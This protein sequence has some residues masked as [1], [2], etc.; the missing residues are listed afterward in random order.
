MST[1][2]TRDV[3]VVAD[4]MAFPENPR[5]RDGRLYFSDHLLA[6]INVVEDGRVA[7]LIEV[8]GQPAGMGW[9]P[10]GEHLVASMNDRRIVRV[11]DGELVEWAQ[12][13]ALAPGPLNDMVVGPGGRAYV[14]SFGSDLMGGEPITPTVLVR[15]DPDG[16][17]VVAAEDLA[18]PNGTAITS[19]G[20]TLVIAETYGLRLT[21]FDIGAGGELSNR[22]IWASFGEP[23]A[24]PAPL[25]EVYAH[26]IDAGVTVPD[27]IALDADGAAWVADPVGGA[28][29]RVVEG[30]TILDHVPIGA[31][32]SYAVALG[33]ADRRTLYIC[34]NARLGAL[35]P[36]ED[37]LGCVLACR[38]DVPG[39]GWM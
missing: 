2:P 20:R 28:V 27:G 18:F 37:R 25:P 35:N 17:A 9:T 15:V 14:G 3:Q 7:Q 34:A 5:W 29:L 19:D 4:G 8:P 32:G 38:V 26:V 39:A 1:A 21:A 16:A 31:L 10:A 30:G 24:L 33:G 12:L 22:R 13:G 23:P 36:R 6:R 11:R